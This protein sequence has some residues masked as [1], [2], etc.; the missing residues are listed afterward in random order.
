MFLNG[1]TIVLCGSRESLDG[2]AIAWATKIEKNHLLVSLPVDAAITNRVIAKENFSVSLLG[3]HQ[4]DI[5]RQYGGSKQS[6][7]LRRNPHDLDFDKWSVPI[8]KSCRANLIC[9]MERNFS[10][11][12]QVIVI[13]NIEDYIFDEAVP[14]LVYDH[15]KYFT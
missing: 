1:I 12:E 6:N 8:V 7:P 3:E 9:T 5:A 15:A 10:I 13:A 14:P 11:E 2:A 4:A